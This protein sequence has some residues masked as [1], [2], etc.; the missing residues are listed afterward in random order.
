MLQNGTQG[1]PNQIAVVRLRHGLTTGEIVGT[2]TNPNFENATT[3]ARSGGT[4]LAVNAQ[5][6]PPAPIDAEPEVVVLDLA[7]AMSA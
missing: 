6:V 5:F 2:V 7:D 1:Q 3:L 4:L